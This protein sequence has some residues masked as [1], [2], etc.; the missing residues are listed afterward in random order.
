MGIHRRRVLRRGEVEF[1]FYCS[2]KL[3]ARRTQSDA[4]NSIALNCILAS[5]SLDAAAAAQS[6]L[7][8]LYNC[9]SCRIWQRPRPATKNGSR[10]ASVFTFARVIYELHARSQ[11]KF[12]VDNDSRGASGVECALSRDL[13]RQKT[14][15]NVNSRAQ[16]EL[17]DLQ[18]DAMTTETE[19]TLIRDIELRAHISSFARHFVLVHMLTLSCFCYFRAFFSYFFSATAT[20]CKHIH[21]KAERA[22]CFAP[23]RDFVTRDARSRS[24]KCYQVYASLVASPRA[25]RLSLPRLS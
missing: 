10:L 4:P 21:V 5:R 20:Q 18:D 14:N 22:M 13:L 15:E 9:E 12:P 7:R 3:V 16:P 23:S 17:C 2:R 6:V 25:G 19:E 8:T 11:V 24:V 1:C